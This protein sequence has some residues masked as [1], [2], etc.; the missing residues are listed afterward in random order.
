MAAPGR[1]VDELLTQQNYLAKIS[2][3]RRSYLKTK[4]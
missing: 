2:G 3:M 4:K 1:R